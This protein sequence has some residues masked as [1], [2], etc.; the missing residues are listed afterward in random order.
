MD[1]EGAKEENDDVKGEEEEEGTQSG[2]GADEV[3]G[4]RGEKEDRE[5]GGQN[6]DVEDA[7][8][9]KAGGRGGKWKK[10]EDDRRAE[11]RRLDRGGSRR[12]G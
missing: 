2:R 3:P 11:G 7:K 10:V 9:E 6:D 12:E 8:E 4:A 5:K 1:K